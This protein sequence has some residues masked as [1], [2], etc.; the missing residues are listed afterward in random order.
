MTPFTQQCEFHWALGIVQGRPCRCRCPNLLQ[1]RNGPSEFHL[2]GSLRSWSIIDKLHMID[3]NTL[4]LNADHDEA[5]DVCVVPFFKN[6]PKVK[7]VTF[8]NASH[9]SHVEKRKRFMEI[10]RGFLET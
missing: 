6:I 10:V 1:H 2:I 5:Q 9:F 7:W 4:V 8:E 3:V